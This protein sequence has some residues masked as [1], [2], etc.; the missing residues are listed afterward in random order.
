MKK[1]KSGSTENTDLILQTLKENP[2]F[3]EI[4]SL[5]LP[6][7]DRNNTICFT[8]KIMEIYIY[9]NVADKKKWA[10]QGLK[11]TGW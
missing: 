4:D 1:N 9:I 11:K 2:K 8:K 5:E 6:S 7:S 10:V 3:G